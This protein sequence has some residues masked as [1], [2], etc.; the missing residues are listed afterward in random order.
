MALSG[1]LSIISFI[2]LGNQIPQNFPAYIYYALLIPVPITFWN[3][4]LYQHLKK[5]KKIQLAHL[6]LADIILVALI[7]ILSMNNQLGMNYIVIIITTV[8]ASVFSALAYAFII[9]DIRL[10]ESVDRIR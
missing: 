6:F 5:Q 8:F 2:L 3:I 1:L 7:V 10:L 9:K 4:F